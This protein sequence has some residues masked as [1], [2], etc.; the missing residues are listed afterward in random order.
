MA[1][2]YAAAREE[3]RA[4]FERMPERERERG[5][6]VVRRLRAEDEARLRAGD[7]AAPR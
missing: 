5:L 6:Q 1:R 2:Q 3:L 7:E 4:V